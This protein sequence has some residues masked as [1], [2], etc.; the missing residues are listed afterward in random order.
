MKRTICVTLC[1]LMFLYTHAQRVRP[2]AEIRLIGD[3]NFQPKRVGS[4]LSHFRLASSVSPV[5]YVNKAEGVFFVP[6][7]SFNFMLGRGIGSSMRDKR[8]RFRPQAMLSLVAGVQWGFNGLTHQVQTMPHFLQPG[9]S[10]DCANIFALASNM[11][12]IDKNRS[13]RG[14]E[15]RHQRV[16]SV[17]IGTGFGFEAFYSNDGPPFSK[18]LG[19]GKDRYWTGSILLGYKFRPKTQF[20]DNRPVSFRW[21]FDRYTSYKEDAYELATALK[22]DYV[23]YR[24]YTSNLYNRG[25][26]RLGV[27]VENLY[28]AEVSFNDF[29]KLDLQN[30]LHKWQGFSWHRTANKSS[31]SLQMSYSYLP[32]FK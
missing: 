12:L 3:I 27:F 18:W 24:N 13:T 22:M 29:D 9:F 14:T 32:K 21:G 28:S 30:Y 6:V 31:V 20:F 11:I 8:G 1:C 16:G 17:Y 15:F 5:I 4:G 23:P 10:S 7:T 19:D 2:Q 26:M 25:S